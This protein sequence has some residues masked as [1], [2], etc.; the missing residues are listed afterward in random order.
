[1]TALILVILIASL[2]TMAVWVAPP[3]LWHAILGPGFPLGSHHL[4]STLLVIYA[5]TT[6][7]YSLSVV[8]MSYEISRKIGSVSWLQLCFS[9]AIIAGIYLFHNTLHDVISVQLI[10]MTAL[11]LTVSIPFLWMQS[12]I[13]L[14]S[15]LEVV[16]E[17][18]ISGN[19]RK[20]RRVTEDEVI[21][22]FLKG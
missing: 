18:P 2:F 12:K 4:Y 17:T 3:G 16:R 7:I 14:Q 13:P 20:I 5:A 1:G 11:L 21:C 8:L 9:G 10:L 15:S 6:G 22:E 19:I